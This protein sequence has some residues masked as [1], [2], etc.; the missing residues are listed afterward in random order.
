MKNKKIAILILTALTLLSVALSGCA[1][2]NKTATTPTKQETAISTNKDVSLKDEFKGIFTKTYSDKYAVEMTTSEIDSATKKQSADYRSTVAI[3]GVDKSNNSAYIIDNP[4]K[5][6]TG[7]YFKDDKSYSYLADDSGQKKLYSSETTA[8]FDLIPMLS[9]SALVNSDDLKD[10]YITKKDNEDGYITYELKLP[11]EITTKLASKL[12]TASDGEKLTNYNITAK[13][14][15]GTIK[16]TVVKYDI[17][18]KTTTTSITINL[19][20][21]AYG[22]EV[23]MPDI[24]ISKATPVSSQATTSSTDNSSK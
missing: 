19:D 7:T 1:S 18:D 5:E 10:E 8:N 20:L 6:P 13:V 12:A 4:D 9:G 21:Q 2:S 23:K 15:N 16:N 22:D 17:V 24:D 14:S 11:D 3:F